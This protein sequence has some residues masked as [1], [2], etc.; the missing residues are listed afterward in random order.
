MKAGLGAEKSLRT[1]WREEEV[2]GKKPPGCAGGWEAGWPCG[3]R[4][5]REEPGVLWPVHVRVA[6]GDTSE[7]AV[8]PL[9]SRVWPYS[10]GSGLG[11]RHPL[12]S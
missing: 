12:Y 2:L 8:C 4:G 7:P 11:H 10:R 1:F 3:E 6:P 9:F 5:E